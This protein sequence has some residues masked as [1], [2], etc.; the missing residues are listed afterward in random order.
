ML[1]PTWSYKLH[2][3]DAA[4]VANNNVDDAVR[5]ANNN[6]DDAVINA[7]NNVD[8]AVSVNDNVGNGVNADNNIGKTWCVC[9]MPIEDY[10]E[11]EMTMVQC[12]GAA[13]K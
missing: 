9:E 1:L 8:D 7:N 13:C 12:Q 2:A 6:V 3:G 10:N 5:V 4:T 11:E